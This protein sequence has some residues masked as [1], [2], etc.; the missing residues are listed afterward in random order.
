MRLD[1]R[2]VDRGGEQVGD[3]FVT[4]VR[5]GAEQMQILPAADARHQFNF[6]SGT[7]EADA[8]D[9]VR[10]AIEVSGNDWMP[11]RYFSKEAGMSVPEL[12]AF[13]DAD[14]AAVPA[15]KK[16]YA[17]RLSSSDSAYTKA[18][19][20]AAAMLKRILAGEDVDPKDITDARLIATA[21]QGMPRPLTID[22]AQFRNLLSNVSGS[23]LRAMIRM[24]NTRSARR[25]KASAAASRPFN[26]ALL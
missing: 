25:A 11:I 24:R 3:V 19:G 5:F 16:L 22:P 1:Q 7:L 14:A 12:L 18:K 6:L 20:P 26:R 15:Q 2:L 17:E 4:G 13:I 9:Y 21:A 10:C 23:L 8:I